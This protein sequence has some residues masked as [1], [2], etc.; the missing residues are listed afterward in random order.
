MA[1][2]KKAQPATFQCVLCQ[3]IDPDANEKKPLNYKP[4]TI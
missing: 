1:Q 4:A 3:Y 2:N